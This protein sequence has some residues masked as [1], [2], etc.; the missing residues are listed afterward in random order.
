MGLKYTG[1]YIEK[2]GKHFSVLN[3]NESGYDFKYA[4][5]GIKSKITKVLLAKGGEKITT[6][7]SKGEVETTVVAEKGDAIFYNNEHDKYIPA[8]S[9]GNHW[10]FAE[11]ENHGYSIVES[12]DGFVN[13]KSNNKGFL[14]VGAVDKPCVIENAFGE[15]QHQFLYPGATLKMDVNTGKITGID[16]EAFE[17]TW[18]VLPEEEYK[19]DKAEYEKNVSGRVLIP[20]HW[21]TPAR[22]EHVT[23]GFMDGRLDK[24]QTKGLYET[25]EAKIV[26][27]PKFIAD[28]YGP[29]L[30]K[31]IAQVRN[32]I[33][34]HNQNHPEDEMDKDRYYY[35]YECYGPTS[36]GPHDNDP[37]FDGYH[38]YGFHNEK[39]ENNDAMDRIVRGLT[40]TKDPAHVLKLVGLYSEKANKKNCYVEDKDMQA[41]QKILSKALEVEVNNVIKQFQNREI[42]QLK[43]DAY[44]NKYNVAKEQLLPNMVKN[45]E[46][47]KPQ[48]EKLQNQARTII[49]KKE[50][51]AANIQVRKDNAEQ[52]RNMRAKRKEQIKEQRKIDKQRKIEEHI[53]EKTK[54]VEFGDK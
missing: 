17:N 34:E 32:R 8:D 12:G 47:Q 40:E 23:D 49:V 38:L 53:A 26:T 19:M 3:V 33:D 36:Y 11:I 18:E 43:F 46:A 54:N 1:K 41:M 21:N 28:S 24:Y 9:N 10:K 14:L 16:K 50:F 39:L 6:T 29:E 45:W 20:G 22:F 2:D 37:G 5:L 4:K 52:I 31:A 27:T 35:K 7:N 51:R 48:R 25:I 30:D 13:I 42:S 44:I 15:G